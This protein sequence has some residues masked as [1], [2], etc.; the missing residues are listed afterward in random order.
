L[1]HALLGQPDLSPAN[2]AKADLQ[3]ANF[4]ETTISD[5]Y[6]A[7]TNLRFAE[8]IDT[9]MSQVVFDQNTDPAEAKHEA[10][11]ADKLYHSMRKQPSRKLGR[12]EQNQVKYYRRLRYIQTWLIK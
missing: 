6:L 7:G 10:Y 3:G 1:P 11:V 12:T 9:K 2:F 8:F 5:A 4:P